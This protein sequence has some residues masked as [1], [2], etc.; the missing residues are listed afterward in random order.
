MCGKLNSDDQ[1]TCQICGA[2]LK[3]LIAGA[4]QET[5]PQKGD[6]TGAAENDDISFAPE[7][8]F[9]SWLEDDD[10]DE[11]FD[12]RRAT[13]T[14]SLRDPLSWLDE[15]SAKN[16]EDAASQ[17]AASSDEQRSKI[18]DWLTSLNADAETPSEEAASEA[19][20]S[21][22]LPDWLSGE[23]AP[24][25]EPLDSLISSD[26]SSLPDI[27]LPD[28]LASIPS[29]PTQAETGN[30]QQIL[31]QAA[32]GDDWLDSLR[33]DKA[34]I[35]SKPE[36]TP[37]PVENDRANI[38][39][40]TL[41]EA[42]DMEI[43]AVE[44]GETPDWLAGVTE[45][46]T[47]DLRIGEPISTEEP[48]EEPEIERA[49][50]PSWLQEMK[51]LDAVS[52]PQLLPEDQDAPPVHAGPLAGLRGVLPVGIQVA[53]IS[54]SAIPSAKL[55]ISDEQEVQ[56]G[57]L[58]SLLDGE[59]RPAAVRGAPRLTTQRILRWIISLI[60]LA[61]VGWGVISGQ[62]GSILPEIPAPEVQ[63]VFQQIE[64]LL[65]GQPVLMA[66]DY[67]TA[68][69][70]E[71]DSVVSPLLA[72]LTLRG[73]PLV[74]LSTQ[75]EGMV[76]AE[77]ALLPAVIRGYRSGEQY[78][79][80]GYLPG[81][82]TGLASLA[83]RLRSAVPTTASGVSAWEL[84]M[85]QN[86]QSVQDFGMVIVLTDDPDTARQWI[87]QVGTRYPATPLVLGVSAQAGPMLSPYYP[88]QIDGLIAGPLGGAAYERQTGM[89]GPAQKTG[90]ALSL[91]VLLAVLLITLGAGIQF[92]WTIS[93]QQQSKG[94]NG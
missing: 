38:S 82:T 10:N 22:E 29:T 15:M 11:I 73:T 48:S 9:P 7:S 57:L 91:G 33:D 32:Q 76:L 41:D 67:Q 19:T 68:Y 1:D 60:L 47:E 64:M 59:G 94:A 14:G 52:T 62:G 70:G 66:F 28:W 71:M 89:S 83:Q 13:Q 40:F 55:E 20:P 77:H 87:E 27:D 81:G 74:A 90:N 46:G 5:P 45:V 4:P 3:P 23:A 30:E 75:P 35:E 49:S 86:V 84:P 78:I 54:K 18:T 58:R 44:A 85:L 24:A 69:A 56:I 65:P 93:G 51:P 43:S 16:Q 50:L 63:A 42:L 34:P 26:T 80:L 12:A 72:H 39:P 88:N 53:H 25:E 37:P 21:E 8:D 17:G 36:S 31:E 79:N 61:A 92:A 2:R 6:Q